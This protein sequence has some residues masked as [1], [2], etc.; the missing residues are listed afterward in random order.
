MSSNSFLFV[1]AVIRGSF[2]PPKEFRELRDLTRYKRK[3]I[4]AIASEKQRIGKILEDAN[5]KLSSVASDIFGAKVGQR[6]LKS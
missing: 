4:Q 2:I 6:L 1:D 5:R 3:L